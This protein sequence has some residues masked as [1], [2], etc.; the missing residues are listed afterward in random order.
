MISYFR[1]T[2]NNSKFVLATG[3]EI[4]L[5][6]LQE[7]DNVE[8]FIYDDPKPQFISEYSSSLITKPCNYLTIMN[9]LLL[10][11]IKFISQHNS[12]LGYLN[13]EKRYQYIKCI[14]TSY[15]ENDLFVATGQVSGK[16]SIVDFQPKNEINLE[17][18]PRQ[19]RPSLSLAWNEQELNLLAMGFDKNK[20]DH[21]IS[22]WDIARGHGSE[23][24]IVNLIGLSESTHSMCWDKKNLIAGMSSKY[25]KLMDLRATQV[26]TVNTRAVNGLTISSNSRLLAGY[27]D[28]IVQFFDFRKFTEPLNQFQLANN[29]AQISWCSTSQN[30]LL[31]LQRDS[32]LALNIIDIHSNGSGSEDDNDGTHFVKRTISPFEIVDRKNKHQL[33][34]KSTSLENICWHPNISNRLICSALNPTNSTLLIEFDIPER[35]IAI[36]DKWNKLFAPTFNEIHEI[37][38]SS[39]PSSPTNSTNSWYPNAALIDSDISEIFQQRILQD[40]GQMDF[41]R[42]AKVCMDSSLAS[43]WKILAQMSAQDC[44]I[45]LRT[46]LGI[47]SK[48]NELTI[49]QSAVELRTF[50]DFTPGTSATIRGY[51]SEEREFAQELCGWTFHKSGT[52]SSL[53]AYIEELCKKKKFTRAAMLSVFHLKIRLACD[54]LGRGAN[55]LEDEKS[56]LRMSAIA[57]AGYSTTSMWKMQCSSAQKQIDDPHLRAIFSFLSDDT[58]GGVLY[59]YGVS[60]SDRMAFACAFLSDRQLS[61]YVKHM[62]QHSIERGDLSGLLVS[63]ATIDGLQ[64][65]QAFVDRSDDVQTA[66]L[67]GQKILPADLQTDNRLQS[68]ITIMRNL[69]N[70]W[71]MFEKRAAFDI[72]IASS[73]SSQKTPK[74]IYLLCSFCGKSVSAAIQEDARVRNQMQG[75]K[76]SSCPN[77]RKPLPRCSLCLLYMGT[78]LP[79]NFYNPLNIKS[80]NIN[81]WFTWCQNCRHG[82]HLIHIKEWFKAHTECPVTSCSCNCFAIDLPLLKEPRESDFDGH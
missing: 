69:M 2:K 21:S 48:S 17:F 81:T 40:Y 78:S 74:S 42:N 80:R 27:Y 77:C 19:N 29:L 53:Q 68:W 73:R 65:L 14:A 43:V 20:F 4:S 47:D 75:S 45:G 11:Q 67:I 25:I 24:S 46:I 15:H 55:D 31:C 63:G 30:C 61:E 12:V 16:V 13:S 52:N 1:N 57:L 32:S 59:E 50:S 10:D 8:E 60:I 62:I 70:T 39:P 33:L 28:N 36:F 7:K 41:E 35:Q 44:F 34:T 18:T 51:K 26:Q 22:V 66:C 38:V 54:I 56:A 5:F 23:S 37:P 64:L 49:A 9:F 72:Q 71:E 79:S 58:Y 6:Q 3:S 76:L 82:G